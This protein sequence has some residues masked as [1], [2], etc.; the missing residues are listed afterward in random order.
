[1]YTYIQYAI[2][3]CDQIIVAAY[4]LLVATTQPA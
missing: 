3:T 2:D 1:M 4:I